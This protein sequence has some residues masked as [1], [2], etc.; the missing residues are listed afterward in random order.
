LPGHEDSEE[1]PNN[2]NGA[3]K[4]KEFTQYQPAILNSS[5]N[6]LQPSSNEGSP[7]G[8]TGGGIKIKSRLAKMIM[9]GLT[10]DLLPVDP[11]DPSLNQYSLALQ[12]ENSKKRDSKS[13][14]KKK[15]TN[16]NDTNEK[17]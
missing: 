15:H 10:D 12:A 7:L 1:P 6:M 13:P 9:A 14:L 17:N 5:L 11:N 2:N 4:S 3:I 16:I 8:G